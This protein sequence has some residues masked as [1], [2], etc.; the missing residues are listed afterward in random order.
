MANVLYNF[1]PW[2]LVNILVMGASRPPL[3]A[4]LSTRKLHWLNTLL[5]FPSLRRLPS[6]Q[7]SDIAVHQK[8]TP[9][10]R[11]LRKSSWET[12]NPAG[13]G[14]SVLRLSGAISPRPSKSTRSSLVRFPRIVRR[15][16]KPR[17]MQVTRRVMNAMMASTVHK[18]AML[19]AN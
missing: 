9:N 11:S 13:D 15:I 10:P 6:P 2:Y 8:G 5:G 18:E 3:H 12:P 17:G 1:Y 14:Y 4:R 16:I 7:V 19:S